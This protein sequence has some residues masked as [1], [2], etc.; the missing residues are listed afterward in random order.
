MPAL[1]LVI[2]NGC[3]NSGALLS[4]S[5]A[6]IDINQHQYSGDFLPFFRGQISAHSQLIISTFFSNSMSVFLNYKSNAE[7]LYDRNLKSNDK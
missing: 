5:C 7:S 2:C 6:E 4:E 1:V 3:R